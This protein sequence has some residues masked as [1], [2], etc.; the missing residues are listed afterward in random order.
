MGG[1]GTPDVEIN[2][3]LSNSSLVSV[4]L[5]IRESNMNKHIYDNLVSK[6]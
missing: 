4:A 3:P 1:G 2:S 6:R 5:P